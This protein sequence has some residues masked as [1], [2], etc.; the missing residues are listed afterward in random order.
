MCTVSVVI[1][2]KLNLTLLRILPYMQAMP[3]TSQASISL[4]GGGGGGG[5]GSSSPPSPAEEASFVEGGGGEGESEEE[6]MDPE[7][8]QM[9]LA[10]SLEG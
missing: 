10:M 3:P 4:G 1:V 9:A 2:S 5:G 8:H 7:M 6:E